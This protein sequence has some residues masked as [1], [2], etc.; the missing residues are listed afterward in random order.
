LKTEK[1]VFISYLN[2]DYSRTSVFLTD[3]RQK[4]YYFWKVQGTKLGKLRSLVALSI[5]YSK[6]RTTFIVMSPC[7]SLVIPLRFL[8]SRPI[9]LDA[10]WSLTEALQVR[11]LSKKYFAHRILTYIID[12]LSFHLSDI[13][14]FESNQQCTWIQNKFRLRKSKTFSIFTGF[15]ESRYANLNPEMPAELSE[16]SEFQEGYVLFRGSFTNEAGLDLLYKISQAGNTIGKRFVIATNR[17]FG[18]FKNC[19]NVISIHRKLS[20]S[21]IKFL[22]L[23]CSLAIGQLRNTLRLANTIPHK[24][25]E[26]AY[27]ARPYLTADATGIR[28]FLSSDNQAIFTKSEDVE[29]LADLLSRTIED[30][31]F[32]ITTGVM[33]KNRYDQV[34]SQEKLQDQFSIVLNRFNRI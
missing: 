3:T 30:K 8:T 4:N 10:G 5:K 12:F 17:D 26:A 18:H 33:A 23:N 32:L 15:N 31:K 22:Y 1:Y 19:K 34:A 28:E 29:V 21:E 14:L 16:R 9:I 11:N 6:A 24:A 7:H 20:E 25:F 2:S 27:F 13:S